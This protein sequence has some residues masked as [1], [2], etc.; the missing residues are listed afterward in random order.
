MGIYS[1]LPT[2]DHPRV[3]GEQGEPGDFDRALAGPP[4]RA[5]GAGGAGKAH[6]PSP[7]TT[8]A[9]AGSSINGWTV[10]GCWAGPPPR[11]RGADDGDG[12]VVRHPG[13]TPACAG[14]RSQASR[15]LATRG[16]HPRVRGEQCIPQH[17]GQVRR[18]PPPRARGAVNGPPSL[19][20][21]PGTTPA[22]AGS[23]RGGP[24]C[25]AP[26][27]GPPPRARGAGPA[28]RSPGHHGRD[29]P[30]VRGEQWPMTHTPMPAVGPPPRARGAGR[31]PAGPAAGRGTTP[32]CAGSSAVPGWSRGRPRDHPRVRGEQMFLPKYAITLRG[33]PP[34][35]RGAATT[36][37]RRTRRSRT[38]PA[39][40]G[41][42][43]RA[44]GR[45]RCRRDHPRVRGEQGR[46][47]A[48]G[49]RLL[50]PPP[51]ARGAG[52]L[53]CGSTECW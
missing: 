14:S 20:R 27:R 23:S 52:F 26:T 42:S 33:P 34:R 10:P 38:T 13:T 16:D 51:R 2:R 53:T 39:C 11:A 35:A 22:C 15:E 45:P 49:R 41:S 50:G 44:T 28:P 31:Q 40:A 21:R 37:R 47:D 1:G 9:C 25:G 30:R 6:P 29:H 3:R 17:D 18:G 36:V 8:P 19:H 4:P 32:A 12:P 7:G 46:R 24:R 43:G 48:H 5:R